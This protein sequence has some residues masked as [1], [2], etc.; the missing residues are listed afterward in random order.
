MDNK[1]ILIDWLTIS[2]RFTCYEDM[3]DFV[4]ISKS[5]ILNLFVDTGSNGYYKFSTSLK[6]NGKQVI[7]FQMCNVSNEDNC[8][9]VFSGQGCR[10]F[11]T[12][13]DITFKQLFE[14]INSDKDVKVT[15]LD[16]A[17]DVMDNK[18]TIDKFL[19]AYRKGNYVCSA[20][21][22]SVIE[23][24]YNGINGTSLYFGR[25]GGDCFIN[26]YDKRAE[27][28]HH[29]SD[30][31]ISWVR[32]ECRIK[33]ELANLFLEQLVLGVPLAELYCGF[34]GDKLR[35]INPNSKDSN[36]WRA[37]IAPWWKKLLSDT[38]RI[39]LSCPGVMYEWDDWSTEFHKQCD[40]RILTAI[41]ILGEE[42]F[43]KSVKENKPKIN[44]KQQFMINNYKP[45]LSFYEL[46]GKDE[47]D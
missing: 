30:M 24:Q 18:Y 10:F 6:L 21:Y 44:A 19:K 47:E 17:Y 34:I 27:R 26:I 13:S 23:S 20:R 14:R 4:G 42:Q 12:Y 8:V 1:L 37:P 38:D 16:L 41:K 43:I 2:G 31:P 40:S 35:F 5:K 22:T 36:K 39:H 11:E 45:D 33:G 3:F 46:G 9:I 29:I 28:E 25:Q 15:R 7:S 32:I